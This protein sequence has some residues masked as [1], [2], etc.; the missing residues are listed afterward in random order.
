[1]KA[2]TMPLATILKRMQ[3]ASQSK[4]QQ[5]RLLII[6]QTRHSR[7]DQK[8]IMEPRNTQYRNKIMPYKTA[9]Q[10]ITTSQMSSVWKV[11]RITMWMKDTLSK[12]NSL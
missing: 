3:R 5:A 4:R 8:T 1:M 6:T 12:V 9:L 11:M 2:T 7:C 10:L